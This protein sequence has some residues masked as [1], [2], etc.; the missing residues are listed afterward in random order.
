[1]GAGSKEKFVEKASAIHCEK[2]DYSKTVYK[3]A[4]EKVEIACPEHGSF[5]MAPNNHL[6]GQGCPKCSSR[7]RNDWHK[8]S[9]EEF[10]RRASKTHN[11][12]Y[13]YSKTE[14]PERLKE[15]AAIICRKHGVFRQSLSNHLKGAG[16]PEC[17]KEALA[18][19]KTISE[20]EFLKRAKEAHGDRYDYSK[21]EY[22]DMKSKICIVCPVHGEFWQTA[23]NHVNAGHGCPLCR[24]S[25]G[26]EKIES[27]LLERKI[28]F[29]REKSFFRPVE[30]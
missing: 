4:L 13:D 22:I 21:T 8:L 16:C 18:A 23:G 27:W 28:H 15:K 7:K 1:M 17:K 25:R 29:E 30:R 26:E 6:N 10:I 9:K 14:M 20:S 24:A 19:Q 2:Y 5:W 12:R 11:S 3:K